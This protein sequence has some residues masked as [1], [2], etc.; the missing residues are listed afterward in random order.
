MCAPFE[1]RTSQAF[2]SHLVRSHLLLLSGS[3]CKKVHLAASCNRSNGFMMPRWKSQKQHQALH[4]QR[5]LLLST[6]IG[7]CLQAVIGT[8]G[9]GH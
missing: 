3:A 5:L 1:A 7:T 4:V 6:S 8:L 9:A 2:I